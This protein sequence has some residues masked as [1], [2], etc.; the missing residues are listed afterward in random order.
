MILKDLLKRIKERVTPYAK[1][2]VAGGISRLKTGETPVSFK[3]AI[4]ERGK[5]FVESAKRFAKE[6]PKPLTKEESESLAMSFGPGAL[7]TVK[8]VIPTVAEKVAPVIKEV[9]RRFVTRAR[10]IIPE[11]KTKIA[12]Q[13][14]PRDT[15]ELSIKA[16][17][18]IKTNI[19]AAERMARTGT[20][21]NAVAVASELT[22]YYNQLAQ[23][24]KGA[25]SIAFYDKAADIVNEIAPKLTK[26]G[27]AIQAAS[28]LSRMTPEGQARFASKL[29]Q[30]YNEEVSSTR[31]GFLGL[32]KKI[33]ELTGEQFKEITT[34]AKKIQS[35]P[36]GTEKAMAY[37]A[38][39]D[40]LSDL[41]PSTMYQKI[42]AV[43]KAGLLTGIKTSGLNV[44][45][46][47][48]HGE[49]EIV[50]D[51]PAVAVD[52]V[53]SLFTGERALAFT[54]KGTM[55]GLK[56]GFKKG[57]RYM[58]T[59]F[60]ERDIGAK[61]D[62]KRVNFGKSKFA[63]TIQTYEESV[64]K[65]IGAEDQPFYYATKARSLQ[66][67]AIA[68]AKNKRLRGEEA[69]KFIDN[70]VKNPTDKMLQYATTDAE[71]SVFQN[72]TVL[73]TMAKGMQRVPGGEVV[74]PFSR[75]P[76]AV[77]TQLI[78]YSPVG[79]VKTIVENIG[80]G[81]FDQRIFSQ[82]MGRGIT[83]TAVL[84]IGGS[85]FK[86][87]LI[88]LDRPETERER[89]QWELEGKKPNSIKIG[90]KWRSINVFGPLGNVLIVGGQFQ[91]G[92]QETGSF[93]SAIAQASTGGIKSLTEQ[94]FLRG[95]DQ[96][97]EAVKDPKRYAASYVSSTLASGVPTIVSDVAR[98]TD[99]QERR[100]ETM[101]GK[102]K[103]RI[104]GLRET[105]E[106]KID[107]LG[108][109]LQ[110]A[111]N[112]IETM[113]DPTRPSRIKSSA[114]IEEL[115]RLAEVGEFATPTD[116]ANEKKKYKNV[117]T[118]EQRT[119]IQERAGLLLEDKL[120]K[121]F[122]I[123]EYKQLSD[124][125]KRKTIQDFTEKSRIVARVEMTQEL[126][127]NLRGEE[128]KAKLAELKTSGFLTREVFKKWQELFY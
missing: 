18:L 43:W 109:P 77:A 2:F 57:W 74:V 125:E 70:L 9:E 11:I 118:S 56:E 40:D 59:G 51:I 83:G 88:A 46:N 63:K 49:S 71:I 30:K 121:L 15:D 93:T 13:Y 31:G 85:L 103:T 72:K 65:I 84:F 68:Q 24:S 92:I 81:R 39:Q 4:K 120:Q 50:K 36:N 106:P 115:R 99:L 111:G 28:I 44:G 124:E 98:A 47:L 55:G 34:L 19:N 123:K 94:T 27:R 38:F 52:K 64:F 100:A 12:G 97:V 73:G 23:K 14:I 76:A 53:T 116:F 89:K 58:K 86:K 91:K 119:Q 80:K 95:L 41:I 37:K 90:G 114:V 8:K 48:F 104:P 66:S 107:V 82:G 29:I 128:L 113:L 26:L 105:L 1:R 45:A 42:I 3:E 22:K 20:D 79:I 112:A 101:G 21:D 122:S 7:G 32:R 6:G 102:I 62:Y 35:M 67:Q 16:K 110:T 126:V 127:Q 87:G 96:F 17:N 61:L 33:P 5:K 75:T 25:E 60:D 54:T 117:L 108:T 69:K 10:K 78:N